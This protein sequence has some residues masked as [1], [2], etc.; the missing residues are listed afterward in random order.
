LEREDFFLLMLVEVASLFKYGD[1]DP[2]S[3][4]DDEEEEEEEED[5]ETPLSSR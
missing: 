3:A 4:E 5:D 1:L 2:I